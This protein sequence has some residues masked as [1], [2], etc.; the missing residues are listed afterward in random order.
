MLESH[1]VQSKV[2]MSQQH[3]LLLYLKYLVCANTDSEQMFIFIMCLFI[4]SLAAATGQ[5]RTVVCKKVNSKPKTMRA[6]VVKSEARDV[7][8]CPLQR[9]FLS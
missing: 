6:V 5:D 3:L 4:F 9:Y 1:R 2:G 8:G 7:C